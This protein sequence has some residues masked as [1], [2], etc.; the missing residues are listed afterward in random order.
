MDTYARLDE[1]LINEDNQD[2]PEAWEI[3]DMDTAAWASRKAHRAS[4]ELARMEAWRDEQVAR[5]DRIVNTEAARSERDLEF[6]T[7]HL[8]AYLSKLVHEGRKTKS[9]DLPGGTIR[10]RAKQPALDIVDDA[11][12]EWAQANDHNIMLRTKVSLD[13]VTFKKRVDLVDGGTVV[14]P[15]TG[16]VLEFA[17]WTEGGDSVSFDA[18]DFVSQGENDG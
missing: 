3:R 5:I 17:R 4:T 9:L 13:R 18:A 10:M 1:A 6:F 8:G 14:Y 11:A 2:T 12:I 15:V 7:N 16:E